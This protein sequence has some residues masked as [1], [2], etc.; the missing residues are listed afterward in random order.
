[1]Q[2]TP[3]EL[4]A[5]DRLIAVTGSSIIFIAD[6]VG[7]QSVELSV[8]AKECIA[9]LAVAG[10]SISRER[11]GWLQLSVDF[12][13]ECITNRGD[14]VHLRLGAEEEEEEEEE[15]SA[16]TINGT[17]HSPSPA[18]T[19]GIAVEL[20]DIGSEKCVDRSLSLDT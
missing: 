12:V 17:H 2:I 15:E 14:I 13:C 16:L 19:R 20:T 8:V 1:M 4:P 9:P 11:F 7:T 5:S 6:T 10:A 18:R 3:S